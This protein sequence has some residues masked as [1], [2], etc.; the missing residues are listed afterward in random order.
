[1]GTGSEVSVSC[2]AFEEATVITS[3]PEESEMASSLEVPEAAGTSCSGVRS[4]KT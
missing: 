2:E 1:M 4:M 3:S